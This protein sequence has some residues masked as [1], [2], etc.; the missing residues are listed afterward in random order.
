MNK[1]QGSES[2]GR[3]RAFRS[4]S[5]RLPLLFLTSG[6]IM[7]LFTLAAAYNGFQNRMTGEYSRLAEGVTRLMALELD[8]DR[9]EEYLELNEASEEYRRMADRFRMLRD[10]Y[11]D[12]LFMYVCR[13]EKDGGHMILDLDTEAV[14]NGKGY[15]AGT[16]FEPDE[17][18]ASQLEDIMAGKETPGY[19]VHT[20][21]DGYLYSYIRPVFRSDGSYACSVGVDFSLDLLYR[22]NQGF[23]IQLA[24]V[25]TAVTAAILAAGILMVRKSVTLPINRLSRCVEKFAFR[26]EEDRMNNIDLLKDLNIHSGDEI[27]DVYR[28]LKSVTRDSLT[29][30]TGLN[31]ARMDIRDQEEQI[32]KISIDAYRDRL[33]GVGNA[34][35]YRQETEKLNREIREG[36]TAFAVAM[37]DINNL[38]MINDTYGHEHGNEYILGCCRMICRRFAHSPVFRIGGD[39]FVAVLRGEDYENREQIFRETREA[40]DETFG[41]PARQPWERYSASAG[42]AECTGEDS[43]TE[44]VFNRADREMYLDK[45]AFHRKAG[46][47]R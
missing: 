13:F 20:K 45:E 1:T 33:T 37:F 6:L 5:V 15:Q 25:L 12:V 40:Y 41:D 17:P 11:P 47:Y 3:K 27:E 30:A 28:V 2:A 7:M 26:T 8:G 21:E 19:A 36:K 16:L 24:I 38:K 42:M 32:S 9:V 18:F 22:K 39:E 4:L 10:N 31:Q 46:A 29:E 43:S 23:L 14:E 34:T 35:A 44:T